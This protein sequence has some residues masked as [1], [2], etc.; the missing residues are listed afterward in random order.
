MTPTSMWLV[1]LAVIYLIAG[2]TIGSLLLAGKGVEMAVWL[3]VLRPLHI[4]FLLFGWMVQLA[5]GV[6]SWILP[7]T[8]SRYSMRPVIAAS[9]CLNI[10]IWMVGL[11]GMGPAIGGTATAA[12]QVSSGLSAILLMEA[13]GRLFQ[14]GAF[15]SFAYHVWPR[16]R[17]FR[18]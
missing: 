3:W 11:S 7:R 17:S 1:R 13:L 10:G 14:I 16:V 9:I 6:A 8:P 12:G 2:T 4:E 5:F 15:A 18:D